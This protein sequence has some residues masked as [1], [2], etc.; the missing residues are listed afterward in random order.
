MPQFSLH[1][2]ESQGDMAAIR[3]VYRMENPSLPIGVIGES[4]NYKWGY[5]G[6]YYYVTEGVFEFLVT[7]IHLCLDEAKQLFESLNFCECSEPCQKAISMAVKGARKKK[8][9]GDDLMWFFY[10]ALED[11]G[12]S[13]N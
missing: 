4:H 2:P 8:L 13:V 6:E 5:N 3:R 1:T 12:K 10:D 7:Q 9:S 11:N